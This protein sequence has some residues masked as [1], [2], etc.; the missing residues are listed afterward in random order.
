MSTFSKYIYFLFKKRFI[1][2]CKYFDIYPMTINIDYKQWK[3]TYFVLC[4]SIVIFSPMCMY[5]HSFLQS[6]NY[7]FFNPGVGQGVKSLGPFHS[8]ITNSPV[9]FASQQVSLSFLF[10]RQGRKTFS[11]LL[12][13]ITPNYSRLSIAN[14]GLTFLEKPP[15]T[16]TPSVQTP[17]RELESNGRWLGSHWRSTNTFQRWLEGALWV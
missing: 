14:R 12:F 1:C 5:S 2:R 8:P 11:Y 13:S 7:F 15:L 3:V 9:A 17:K 16:T 10:G 4:P 6:L